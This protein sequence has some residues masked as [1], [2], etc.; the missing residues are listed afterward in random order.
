MKA[1]YFKLNHEFAFQTEK[2]IETNDED[3]LNINYFAQNL[4]VNIQNYFKYNHHCLTIWKNFHFEFNQR[5][6]QNF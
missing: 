1:P 4:A 6:S 2:P 5:P 3:G